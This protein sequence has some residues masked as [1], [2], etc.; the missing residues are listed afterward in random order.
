MTS[1]LSAFLPKADLKIISYLI[2]LLPLADKRGAF[3]VWRIILTFSRLFSSINPAFRLSLFAFHGL[4]Q[5]LVPSFD[6]FL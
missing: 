5:G 4:I 6:E 2:I 3:L 1:A